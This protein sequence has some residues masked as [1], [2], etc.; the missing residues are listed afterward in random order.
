M[1]TTA[2]IA[3]VIAV[4]A[5]A[6]AVWAVWQ[7][8]R[9]KHLR[10]K[11]GPE[12]DYTVQ[13]EGDRRKA[14]AELAARE[15]KAK[16]LQIRELTP[17]ERDEFASAWRD[18]QARFVEDPAQAVAAADALVSRVM[19]ARGYPTADYETQAAYASVDHARVI[20]DYREAHAIAE[21][22][23]R[24]QVNTEDLRRAMISYRALFESLVGSPVLSSRT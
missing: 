12:Y 5:L 9:T 20:G 4:V 1:N 19:T 7:T 21:R 2:M 11:F 6:V 24:G 15:A 18:Q 16:R 10:T 13:R 23:H 22:C 8:Q 17:Q 3:V 14:E